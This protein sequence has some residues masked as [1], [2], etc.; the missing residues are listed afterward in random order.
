MS[1]LLTRADFFRTAAKMIRSHAAKVDGLSEYSEGRLIGL[2]DGTG[3]EAVDSL[4]AEWRWSFT[5]NC[6]LTINLGF[7]SLPGQE[8]TI[9]IGTTRAPKLAKAVWDRANVELNWSGCG[10]TMAQAAQ[11]L[12][13]Y[14]Q[15]A[16]LGM[17][18]QAIVDEATIYTPA[19]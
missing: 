13:L 1:V 6:T 11:A 9:N 14:S 10:R 12:D 3:N 5:A 8:E 16:A 7:P 4:S 17:R 15:V 19:E 18:L 2:L